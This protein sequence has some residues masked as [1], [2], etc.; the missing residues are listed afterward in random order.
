MGLFSGERS[1]YAALGLAQAG[2]MEGPV[3]DDEDVR[4]Q[5]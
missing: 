5:I 4:V 2:Q 3:N 1:T